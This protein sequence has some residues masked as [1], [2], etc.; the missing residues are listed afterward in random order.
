[1]KR[2]IIHDNYIR[3]FNEQN[4]LIHDAEVSDTIALDNATLAQ[5]CDKVSEILGES[6]TLGESCDVINDQSELGLIKVRIY[7]ANG[8]ILNRIVYLKDVEN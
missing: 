4:E 7:F 6:K 3:I 1:M 8:R 5:A 2:V